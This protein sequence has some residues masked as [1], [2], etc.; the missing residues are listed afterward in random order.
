VCEDQ[1]GLFGVI[2]PI[3][4]FF[5]NLPSGFATWLNVPFLF[6][7][8]ICRDQRDDQG[9]LQHMLIKKIMMVI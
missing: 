8:Y 4:Y 7:V 9:S 6:V 5:A 1:L 3:S 2:L